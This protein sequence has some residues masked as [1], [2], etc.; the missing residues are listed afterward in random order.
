MATTMTR[1]LV[2][3]GQDKWPDG[4]NAQQDDITKK[5]LTEFVNYK[6]EEYAAYNYKDVSHVIPWEA[7]TEYF[8]TFSADNFKN[9]N[10]GVIR[11]FRE[12]FRQR[13][14]WVQKKRGYPMGDALFTTVQ[15]EEPEQWTELEVNDCLLKGEEFNSNRIKILL[16]KTTLTTSPQFLSQLLNP[17]LFN[18]QPLNLDNKTLPRNSQTLRSYTQTTIDT[19]ARTT[20]LTSS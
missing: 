4:I 8:H 19:L 5:D 10:Q 3:E 1:N 20:T 15:E 17:R 16:D 6:L 9:C 13:G 18:Y 14:V 7:F 12:F 11:N 2:A